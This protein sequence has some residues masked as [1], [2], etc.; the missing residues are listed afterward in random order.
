MNRNGEIARLPRPIREQINCRLQAGE[1]GR[2]ILQ[3]LNALPEVAAVVSSEFQG[4]PISDANLTA[5]KKGGYRDWEAEQPVIKALQSLVQRSDA[6][7]DDAPGVLTDRIKDFLVSRMAGQLLRLDGAGDLA[8]QSDAL[9]EWLIHLAR[10]RR[11]EFHTRRLALEHGR[12]ELLRDKTQQELE[13]YCWKWAAQPEIRAQI[14]GD[15]CYANAEQRPSSGHVLS[16]PRL[17]DKKPPEPGG[18]PADPQK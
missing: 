9:G 16:L 4:Q 11:S 6:P 12:M 3:W 1:Q 15:S 5:W 17:D 8:A 18:Q 14:C 2:Q 7:K 13:E 10:V